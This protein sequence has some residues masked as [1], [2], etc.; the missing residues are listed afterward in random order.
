MDYFVRATVDNLVAGDT[1][2]FSIDMTDIDQLGGGICESGSTTNA[3]HTQDVPASLTSADHDSG[4][5]TDKF[6]TTSPVTDTLYQFKL[7]RTGIVTVTDLRVH[8]TISGG[9]NSPSLILAVKSRFTD[10][11]SSCSVNKPCSIAPLS[12]L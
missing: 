8:F 3:V 11:S 4:Q 10:T 6:T 7:S 9:S 12:D 1:T 2:T 5:V